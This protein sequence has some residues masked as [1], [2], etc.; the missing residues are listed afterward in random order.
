MKTKFLALAIAAAI[1]SGCASQAPAPSPSNSQISDQQQLEAQ[2]QILQQAPE[3]VQ[4][5]RKIAVGRLSN[6]TN[7]GRSL[8]R[9][10]DEGLFDNKIADMFNQA[11]VNTNNFLIFE[12]QDISLLENEVALNDRVSEMVGVDTLV[13]GSLTEFGR[14]TTGER[15]FLSSSA[16]QEATATVDIRLVD[17]A[18]GQVI[19]SVTGTGSSSNEQSRTMGFG[20][21]SGYDGS[22][23]DQAIGAAVNAAVAK[24]SSLLLENPWSADILAV[25]EGNIYISGG[26][27]QGIKIGQTFAVKTK[28]RRVNSGTTGAMIT[29]P[30]SEVAK[31][32][33][34]GTFGRTELDQGSFGTLTEGSIDGYD[35]ATL[36]I[37]ELAK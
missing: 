17:V 25:E 13:I 9:G 1:C 4:L 27:A 36:E 32:E 29:L 10:A 8:L 35:M 5:K 6:E 3:S 28:G 21:V 34:A 31:L 23:N 33:I 20:S 30:G 15:G 26:E 12:R 18:T 16:K 14:S 2:Q 22:L 7:Y 19:A 24:M 37:V 11:I